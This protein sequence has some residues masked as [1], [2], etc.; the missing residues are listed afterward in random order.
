MKQV[1]NRNAALVF[2]FTVSLQSQGAQCTIENGKCLKSIICKC[3]PGLKMGGLLTSSMQVITS[4]CRQ[5][6]SAE[7]RNIMTLCHVMLWQFMI[8]TVDC[9]GIDSGGIIE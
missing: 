3:I 7:S 1:D 8:K 4:F 5:Q 6:T 9:N 2:S